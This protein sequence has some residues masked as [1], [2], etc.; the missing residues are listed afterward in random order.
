MT[1]YRRL[2]C[3]ALIG[4]LA[5]AAAPRVGGAVTNAG[6]RDFR[7]GGSLSTPTGEK[8]ESK[9]WWNDGS[10]WGSLWD[11]NASGYAIHRLNLDT[12]SWV[13]TG[14]LVDTRGSSR[15]DA[16]WRRRGGRSAP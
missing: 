8:P 10:W 5:Q 6:F 13:S 11:P 14:T 4:L 16:R 15:A 12:Q 3:L 7:F 9:L 1:W 2:A